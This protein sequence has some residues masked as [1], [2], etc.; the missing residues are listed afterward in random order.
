[1]KV[2]VEIDCTPEEAR[3]FLG[4]PDVS[5]ANSVYVD[6]ISKAM[7]GAGSVEQVQDFAKNIAPMGQMGLK[8]FQQFMESGNAFAA[9]AAKKKDD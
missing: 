6:V 4:L 8:L 2:H 5:K 9:G 3:A 1:M 7:K